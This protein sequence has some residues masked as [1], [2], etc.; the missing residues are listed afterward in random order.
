MDE[1]VVIDSEFSPVN[2]WVFLL[3]GLIAIIFGAIALV[4]APYVV[5]LFAYFIGALIIIYSISTI[6]K[7]IVKK[8][9]TKSK[10]V[11]VIIG[12]I[13]LI[14]GI[15][16]VLNVLVLWLTIAV[17]IAIW[18]LITGFGDLWLGLTAEKENG[19]YRLLLS[20]TGIIGIALGIV[21][22]I[23]PLLGT[24]V[25]VQVIGVFAIA[26]GIVDLITGFMVQ[27]KL[28]SN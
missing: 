20:I 22:I 28:S 4:W 24:V 3:Q 6:I 10:A 12:I 2:W 8:D 17:L 27:G 5:D 9:S 21:L 23:F 7:G 19:W 16:A 18:A 14:I 13:G 11:L 1:V 25:I 26:I 15:L